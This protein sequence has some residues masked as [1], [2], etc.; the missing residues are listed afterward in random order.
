MGSRP[1]IIFLL[2][3]ISLIVWIL[4][5]LL[6]LS[7]IQPRPLPALRAAGEFALAGILRGAV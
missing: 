7:S 2:V 5:A 4:V 6:L 1:A 3:L